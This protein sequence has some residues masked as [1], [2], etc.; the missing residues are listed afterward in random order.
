MYET[1]ED[2]KK[3]K[4]SVTMVNGEIY[5]Y[6]TNINGVKYVIEDLLKNE[7]GYIEVINN[8]KKE[9]VIKTD[10]IVSITKLKG[11]W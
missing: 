4:Y 9:T 10:Y 5:Y 2:T 7:S 11:R 3:Y 1:H 6:K 8:E